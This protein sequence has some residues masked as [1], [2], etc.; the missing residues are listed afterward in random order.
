V[1]PRSEGLAQW[2]LKNVEKCSEM[3]VMNEKLAAYFLPL[4]LAIPW[5]KLPVVMMLS[6]AFLN[7]KE[8][9]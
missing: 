3:F 5:Q 4:H 2:T 6:E 9:Q 1:I 8:A 7:W